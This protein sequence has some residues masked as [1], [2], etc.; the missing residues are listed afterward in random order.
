MNSYLHLYAA[1][2]LVVVI[3]L[4]LPIW[5]FFEARR[6]RQ[7]CSSADRIRYYRTTLAALWTLSAGS[8]WVLGWKHVLD[9]GGTLGDAT[10]TLANPYLRFSLGLLPF[11]FLLLALLPSL[12]A[13]RK[14]KVRAAYAR[15][16]MKSK[17][18]FL[19]PTN[20][21][22][23]RYFAA[24]SISAGVCEEV[25]FRSF[26]VSYFHSAPFFLGVFVAL[27][28]SSLLFGINHG[29]Q[30]PAGILTTGLAGL[31]FG[32]IYFTTGSLVFAMVLHALTDLRAL[33]LLG[34]PSEAAPPTEA[35][36]VPQTT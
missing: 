9:A 26:L 13:L 7:A 30:G 34:S 16:M 5:D 4:V 27:L 35:A 18:A 33:A 14:P 15:A 32:L 29:Y 2:T 23:R 20:L 11:L 31:L 25:V 10:R 12:L 21:L 8:I 22:E 19:F 6:L 17:F 28:A 1:H 3:A 36:A 24:L